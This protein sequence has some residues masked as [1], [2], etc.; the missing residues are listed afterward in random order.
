MRG[1][2]HRQNIFLFNCLGVTRPYH[3]NHSWS[4]EYSSTNLQIHKYSSAESYGFISP[5]SPARNDE[6]YL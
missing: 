1:N 2:L 5:L 3:H 4:I 6:I